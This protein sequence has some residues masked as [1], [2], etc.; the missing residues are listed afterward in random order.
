MEFDKLCTKESHE[1]GAEVEIFDPASGESTEVFIHVL[2]PDS[3]AWRTAI[4][5]Q[6][7]AAIARKSDGEEVSFED[8]EAELLA[9]VTIGWRGISRNGDDLPFSKEDCITLY[10]S[11]PYILDQVNQFV[12]NRVNFTKG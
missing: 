6:T 5:E 2:G 4:K 12:G 9:A 10:R 11:A 7:K 1:K 8:C 3:K